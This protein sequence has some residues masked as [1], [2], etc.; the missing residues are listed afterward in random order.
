MG[1]AELRVAPDIATIEVGV[2]TQGPVVADALADNN[3]R[4]SRVIDALRQLKI[5]DSDIHTSSFMIQPKYEK[6]PQGDYDYD[7]LRTVIGYYIS[8]KVTITVTDMSKIA[9]IIDATVQAGANASGQVSFDVK[10]LTQQM[11]KAREAAIGSAFH[12]AQIL[13]AAA[14]LDLGPALSITDN[15]ANREY[16]G[17]ASAG[18]ETVVVTGSRIPSTP[19]LPGEIT[20]NSQVNVVYALK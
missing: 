15:Q 8:N 17:H 6:R 1:E 19:I 16:N 10:N 3:A 7:E 9:K 5:A 14:H 18:V 11:D 2:V 13:A 4:M 20:L 12:K